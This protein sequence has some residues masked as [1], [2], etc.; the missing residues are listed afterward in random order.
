[1]VRLIAEPCKGYRVGSLELLLSTCPKAGRV[2]SRPSTAAGGDLGE[3]RTPA[4]MVESFVPLQ[5]T[6]QWIWGGLRL[7]FRSQL[8]CY[9]STRVGLITP[10]KQ[11]T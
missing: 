4:T 3:S 6:H 2:S 9:P 10:K 7:E 1:M 11:T 5:A 8:S